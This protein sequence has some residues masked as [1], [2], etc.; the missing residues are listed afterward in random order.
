MRS[1]L[2]TSPAGLPLHHHLS[3]TPSPTC[4]SSESR[5][6]TVV[7][8]GLRVTELKVSTCAGLAAKA[9]TSG[10]RRCV[11]DRSAAGSPE[12]AQE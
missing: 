6:P 7:C 3:P 5:H 8:L 4:P 2:G 1:G 11:A 12:E 9:A 10:S